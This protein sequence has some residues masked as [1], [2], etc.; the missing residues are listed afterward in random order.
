MDPFTMAAIVNSEDGT[1]YR[2]DF[3]SNTLSQRVVLTSGLGE[4]YT[5]T[6]IGPD[7]TAYAV[8][9]AILFAVGN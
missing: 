4:A 5:P 8:N 6:I 3:K 7:G 2:W 1:V 9:D